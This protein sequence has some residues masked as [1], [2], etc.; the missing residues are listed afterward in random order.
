M[1]APWIKRPVFTDYVLV[2]CCANIGTYMVSFRRDN[3]RELLMADITLTGISSKMGRK[4][5][6][7]AQSMATWTLSRVC[8]WLGAYSWRSM[9]N[10]QR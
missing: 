8:N 6:S 7:C 2:A 9:T 1:Y 3:K 4:S 5:D 10:W